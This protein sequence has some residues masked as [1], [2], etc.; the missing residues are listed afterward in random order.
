MN[1]EEHMVESFYIDTHRDYEQPVLYLNKLK[2]KY[3]IRKVEHIGLYVKEQRG[4][5]VYLDKID[6]Q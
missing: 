6:R 5:K 3:F 4:Q 2:I 1:P